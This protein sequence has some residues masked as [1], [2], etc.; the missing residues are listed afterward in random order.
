M[1]GCDLRASGL[2]L[3]LVFPLA[4]FANFVVPDRNKKIEVKGA[5]ENYLYVQDAD[6]VLDF[7][8]ESDP[9][10]LRPSFLYGPGN[11]GP[12]VVEFYSPSCPHCRKFRDHY[13]E[14]AQQVR[15]LAYDAGVVPNVT[16]H[17]VSCKVNYKLCNQF[18][19]NGYPQLKAFPAGAKWPSEN[20]KFTEM[21]PLHI[22]NALHLHVD[23]MKL[24]ELQAPEVRNESFLTGTAQALHSLFQ[25]KEGKPRTYFKR[26]KEQMFD[27]AYLSFD[28]NLR[29]GIFTSKKKLLPEAKKAFSEWLLLLK[30]VLP[31]AWNIHQVIREI[32]DNFENATS[33]EEHLL[34]IINQFPAPT[35]KWS[36]ACTKGVAGM[37]YSC[38]LWEL[39]HIISVRNQ[40]WA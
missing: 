22:L 36:P 30:K 20:L 26:T 18:K 32:L 29:N 24:G 23:R 11:T 21:H 31:F 14:L 17:A 33:G 6:P 16:F 4:S 1:V 19:I 37:G 7:H 27:D 34:E 38:G 2:L 13:V 15:S 8:P 5:D 9:N 40:F 10:P 35:K 12:R 39:F 25:S 3:L 28:F